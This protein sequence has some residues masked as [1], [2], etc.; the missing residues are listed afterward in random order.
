M[1]EITGIPHDQVIGKDQ[2]LRIDQL[3]VE[4]ERCLQVGCLLKILKIGD[5]QDSVYFVCF[6]CVSMSKTR[7]LF[8]KKHTHKHNHATKKKGDRERE[9]ES[10]TDVNF[11]VAMF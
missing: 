6:V 9:R 5:P 1:A 4:S 11:R 8:C 7:C 2:S 10:Q 3:V